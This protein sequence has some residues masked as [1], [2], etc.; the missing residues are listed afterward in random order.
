[1]IRPKLVYTTT[2]MASF[3]RNDVALLSDRYSVT[4]HV[5]APKRKWLTPWAMVVQCAFLLRHLPSASVSV[6]QFG[7][8][9]SFLP[10]LLGRLFRVPAVVSLGGFDC[11]S[12]PS[13]RYGAHHRVPMGPLTRWSLR[14]ARHLVP[15]SQNLVKSRQVYS[16]VPGDP[17]QQ[18]YMA[19]DPRNQTPFTVVPYGYDAE[20]FRPSGVRRPRSFLTVAQMNP[21]NYERKGIDLLFAVAERFPDYGFSLVGSGPDMRYERVPQNVTLLSFIEHGRLPEVYS[22]HAYYL[23]LSIWEGFPSALCEAMLCGCVPI[24]SRVAAMPDIV[25]DTG[26]YLERRDAGELESVIKRAIESDWARRSRSARERIVRNHPPECRHPFVDIVAGLA[27]R[28]VI[29]PTSAI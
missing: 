18:G 5:F 20:R 29:P 2:I 13:F 15:C 23:Q 27:R 6:T 4:V 8:Y 22:A 17:E 26:F 24:V 3:A 14:L 28:A 16:Q 9:H 25:G 12:F 11:A 7:G 1:M 10:A 21:S 19:F